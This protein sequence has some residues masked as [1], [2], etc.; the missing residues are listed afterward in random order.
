[1]QE[2]AF[3]LAVGNEVFAACAGDAW[4]KVPSVYI[5]DTTITHL[6]RLQFRKGEMELQSGPLFW[7]RRFAMDFRTFDKENGDV[8]VL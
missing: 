4:R 2:L 8:N 6:I 5:C 1:M 3:W 7:R